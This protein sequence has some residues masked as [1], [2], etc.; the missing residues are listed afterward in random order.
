MRYGISYADVG[1]V[2]LDG[3]SRRRRNPGAGDWLV[4]RGGLV[5]VYDWPDARDDATARVITLWVAE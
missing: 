3:H 2:V 1:D 5:V 4:R